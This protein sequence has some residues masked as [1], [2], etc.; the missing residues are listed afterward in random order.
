MIRVF[1]VDDHPVVRRG[2]A[3]F[4]N[5]REGMEVCGDDADASTSISSINRTSPDVVIVDIRLKNTNGIDL[6][7]AITTRYRKIKTLV[8]SMHDE[9]EYVERAL[10]AGASG[11]V[12]KTD[13]EDLI[14]EAIN[15][16][17]A[18]EIYLS[19]SLRDKMIESMIW[20][21]SNIDDV[22]MTSL[23]DREREIFFLIGRGLN[24]RQIAQRLYLSTSTVGTYRERIKS[25]LHIT[26]PGELVRYAV[27]Q[28]LEMDK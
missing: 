1:I 6:I 22:N 9:N 7:K 5:S 8:L 27:K 17:L 18:G 24:T 11:Y 12:L 13:P 20:H 14:I 25:K 28:T 16:A 15:S 19:S 23:S 4:I 3:Q 10:R 26:T 21:S 2:L